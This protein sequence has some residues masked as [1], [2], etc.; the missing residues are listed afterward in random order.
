M[1][2][3]IPISL[4]SL[5]VWSA[6]T[7]AQTGPTNP[8]QNPPPAATASDARDR[9]L[10]DSETERVKPLIAK[11]GHNI[12]LDQRG[13]WTSPF[14]MRRQNAG[15]WI[16]FATA[17]GALIATDRI[18]ATQLPNTV[19]QTNISRHVSNIGSTYAMAGTAAG[20]Y[21]SGILADNHKARET[22]LLGAEALIDSVITVEVLKL[23]TQRPRPQ[24]HNGKGSFFT[25]GDSFPSGHAAA[26]WALAAVVSAEYNKNVLVPI[27]AYSLAG[28]VSLSRL[29]G[30]KHFA[31]DIVAGSAMGW[32]MGHY[33]YKTHALHAGHGQHRLLTPPTPRFNPIADP[34]R[35]TFGLSLAWGTPAARLKGL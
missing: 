33:V 14:R 18:T 10:Y 17:T 28:L 32:F 27:A 20:F 3:A 21:I 26:S 1:R 9:V 11:I 25:G 24:K 12:L 19:D 2:T 22:G 5:T 23:A 13:I 34:S 31:S 29:S 15:W 6:I 8:D 30:Q 35:R 4:I 7:S 16:L